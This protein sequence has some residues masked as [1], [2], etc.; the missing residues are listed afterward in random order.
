[1]LRSFNSY[2][3]LLLLCPMSKI[4]VNMPQLELSWLTWKVPENA[5]S[6]GRLLICHSRHKLAEDI[7]DQKNVRFHYAVSDATGEWK[8]IEDTQ[9]NENKGDQ[10]TVIVDKMEENDR[11]AAGLYGVWVAV[12]WKKEGI[13]NFDYLVAM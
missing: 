12:E 3:E 5:V 7:F 13:F 11:I 1:V 6:I 9:K 8:V 10:C 2:S 4:K